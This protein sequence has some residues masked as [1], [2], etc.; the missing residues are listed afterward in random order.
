M[1]CLSITRR[2]EI[3]AQIIAE[4]SRLVLLEEAYGQSLSGGIKEYR[5]DSGEGSQRTERHSPKELSDLIESTERR[6]DFLNR[7][8]NGTNIVNLNLRRTPGG[9]RNV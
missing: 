5:F 6:I 1:S 4:T 2:A 7:K 3:T 9:C 8:L